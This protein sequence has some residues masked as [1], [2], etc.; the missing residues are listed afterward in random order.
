LTISARLARAEKCLPPPAPT[1]P[2]ARYQGR[3]LDDIREVLR[4]RLWTTQE[5]TVRRL[6]QP[7]Y[8]VAVKSCHKVGKSFLSACLICYEYDCYHP[9][10]TLTTAPTKEAVCDQLWREVRILRANAGR[11]GFRAEATPQLWSAHDHWAKG[12]T[13]KSGE[14]FQGK[15]K[16]GEAFQGKHQLHMLF[17]IDEAVG[18]AP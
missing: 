7:P 1:N 18:V 2:F 12:L 16:S 5:E 10:L 6:F 13:A 4:Q 14:A 8:K 15:H 3:P 17:I 9:S 11:G